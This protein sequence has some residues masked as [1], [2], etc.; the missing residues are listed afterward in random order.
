MKTIYKS[1][2][3]GKPGLEIRKHG[4]GE[5]SLVKKDKHYDEIVVIRDRD[6]ELIKQEYNNLIGGMR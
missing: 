5:F 4:N 1:E 3:C 6:S 2:Y